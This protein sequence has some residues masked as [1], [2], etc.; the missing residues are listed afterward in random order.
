MKAPLLELA[1]HSSLSRRYPNRVVFTLEGVTY[2]S[3]QDA[4]FD[5]NV[6]FP[7][8]ALFI[9]KGSA[10]IIAP[11]DQTGTDFRRVGVVD[12][13]QREDLFE[14]EEGVGLVPITYED[15]DGDW[16]LEALMRHVETVVIY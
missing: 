1:P 14:D 2:F 9:E 3:T 12:G 7:C 11:V 5:T 8:F 4:D 6:V 16:R 13:F 10:L 15:L